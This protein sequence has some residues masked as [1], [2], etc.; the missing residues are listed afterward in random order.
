M[1]GDFLC[2]QRQTNAGTDRGKRKS[3]AYGPHVGGLSFTITVF[4]LRPR[5]LHSFSATGLRQGWASV[6]PN[7]LAV[8]QPHEARPSN[9]KAAV[10]VSLLAV[11]AVGAVLLSPLLTYPLGRDQ[12]VFAT[13]ADVMQRGGMPY[14]D[15]WDTK[16][17]GIFY[18]FWLS[19]RLFGRSEMAPRLLD[20]LWMLATAVAVW[21][22]A[23][24]LLSSWA[25]VAAGLIL[26]FRYVTH[27]YYWHTTQCDGFAALPL[28]LAALALV[29]A[30]ERKSPRWAAASGALVAVAIG[31]KFT[32]GIFLVLPLVAIGTSSAESI[33][34]RLARAAACLAG[35]AGVLLLVGALMWRA[36]ALKPMVETL[37]VWDSQYARVEVSGLQQHNTLQEIA[38]FLIGDPLRLLFPIG[39]LAIVGATD[40]AVRPES[41]R[42]RWFVPAWAL[43]MTA[44]IW[45]QGRYYSYHWLPVLPPLA[46]L[47]AQGLRSAALLPARASKQWV[48]RAVSVG[49]I[50]ALCAF[51]AFA[52]WSFLKFPIRHLMGRVPRETYLRGFDAATQTDFSLLEDRKVADWLQEHTDATDAVFVWGFESLVYFLAGRPPA[53]R[54]IHNLPLIAH[55][56]PPEWRA[57]LVRDIEDRRPLYILVVRNDAQPWLAGRW[58]DSASQLAQYPELAAVLKQHYALRESI[59]DFDIWEHREG[60]AQASDPI[61][62]SIR[63]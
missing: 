17:P 36:G 30:E 35:C 63:E 57:E 28:T 22:L 15:A 45:V 16:P 60:G 47:A 1:T 59:E 51:L 50:F 40:L 52:Y 24:R 54:F 33:R 23:R 18:V 62:Q 10:V 20:L 29:A 43:A 32:L 27:G 39:L 26:T 37:F 11:L 48:E 55:W 56:S 25:G 46:I 19:F 58:D 34:P 41:G 8:S 14:K 21:A 49:G 7:V 44:Q 6:S 53:S 12:G 31:F 2:C 3:A 42:M 13:V 61:P 4:P 9:N 5:E 38:R